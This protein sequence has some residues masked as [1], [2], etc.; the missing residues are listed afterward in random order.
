MASSSWCNLLTFLTRL[1]P[2]GATPSSSF[3]AF[4]V[5]FPF[6]PFPYGHR[7][8]LTFELLHQIVAGFQSG[9]FFR[10]EDFKR[11]AI[12]DLYHEVRGAACGDD[13]DVELHEGESKPVHTGLAAREIREDE[14]ASESRVRY[15]RGR[16]VWV[17]TDELTGNEAAGQTTAQLFRIVRISSLGDVCA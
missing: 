6:V 13:S 16:C 15:V 11:M 9:E 2:A 7:C 8:A 3:V 10:G 12:D 17:C 1:V 5:R 14:E 4:A